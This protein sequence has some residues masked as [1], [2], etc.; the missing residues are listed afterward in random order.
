METR[1]QTC[2]ILG[3]RLLPKGQSERITQRLEEMILKLA[4]MGVTRFF[5]GGALGFETLAAQAV[6]SAREKNPDIRFILVL[7]CRD[8]SAKWPESAVELYE[9]IK[10]RADEVIYTS[11]TASRGYILKRNRYMVDESDYC[12][13]YLSKTSGRTAQTIRY[14]EKTDHVV[15]NI[16]EA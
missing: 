2:C 7:P 12:L 8:Q 10:S 16:A 15:I 3:N 9:S 1:R 4:Q 13:T 11:E 14:A 5:T 6:L